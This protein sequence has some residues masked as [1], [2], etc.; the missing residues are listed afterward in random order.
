MAGTAL[1]RQGR[2]VARAKSPRH[3]R[4]RLRHRTHRRGA[5]SAA[6]R[7][8][9]ARARSVVTACLSA[10]PPADRSVQRLRP[11]CRCTAPAHGWAARRRFGPPAARQHARSDA[12]PCLTSSPPRGLTR[13]APAPLRS[14]RAMTSCHPPSP[15]MRRLRQSLRSWRSAAVPLLP[16]PEGGADGVCLTTG[17][18]PSLH[19]CAMSC[20]RA[21]ASRR[22]PSRRWGHAWDGRAPWASTCRPWFPGPGRH[23]RWRALRAMD[24]PAGA[25]VA[26]SGVTASSGARRSVARSP[27]SPGAP[28][29]PRHAHQ[30]KHIQE[31]PMAL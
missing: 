23:S 25:M 28:P 20:P 9:Q 4:P 16:A 27:R 21:P 22:D 1:R 11:R 2:A 17:F 7:P 10:Q 6:S 12:A 29:C 5:A 3:R 15:L 18:S 13:K 24:G 14:A 31:A 30:A 19:G 8:P 26:G